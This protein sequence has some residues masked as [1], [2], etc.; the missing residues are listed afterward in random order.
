MP[1]GY[2]LRC[3]APLSS[4]VAGSDREVMLAKNDRE[5]KCGL[6]R[7]LNVAYKLA[8]EFLR[9]LRV[10]PR[11]GCMLQ[12]PLSTDD[13]MNRFPA[14]LSFLSLFV[15]PISGQEPRIAIERFGNSVRL[16]ID[17]AKGHEFMLE[18]ASDL[19]PNAW[20]P[21]VTSKPTEGM[22][23]WSE[24]TSGQHFYRALDLGT[25]SLPDFATNFRLTD[26]FNVSHELDYQRDEDAVV[27]I[28]ADNATLD[29]PAWVESINALPNQFGKVVFWMINASETDTRNSI[30]E[31][32]KSTG[33]RI[34][35]LHDA[36]RLVALDISVST[37]PEVIA[38]DP[39][40]GSIFYRGAITSP[41]GSPFLTQALDQHLGGSPVTTRFVR[42]P[43]VGVEMAMPGTL[44]YTKD[45]APILLK[46]C[47]A[48][49]SLGNIAPFSMDQFETVEQWADQMKQEVLADRMPP[50]HADPN[51]GHFTNDSRIPAED[52]ALLVE[53]VNQGTVRGEGDDPLSNF[54][55]ENPPEQNYPFAWPPA[56]G[57]PDYII[58]IPEQSLRS[59]GEIDYRYITVNAGLPEDV[60]LRAAVVLPS[61][62]AVVH[63][64]LMFDGDEGDFIGGLTGYF[65]WYV[66]GT[67]AVEFPEGTGKFLKK[68]QDMTFQMHYI[69]TGKPEKD[70]TKLGLYV[71][72]KKPERELVTKSAFSVA[73]DIPPGAP[74]HE[75]TA[76]MTIEKDSLLYEM[77]PHMHFRG[78]RF[79]YEANYPD[80]TKEILL[81]V[82]K[83]WFDWQ[84]VYRFKEP[85]LLPR[86]TIVECVGAFDNSSHNHENPNPNQRVRFG[87]QT[88][89][90]MF[91]GYMNIVELP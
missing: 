81:S 45:I 23:E 40:F 75:I 65:S 5:I 24:S 14:I 68:D 12:E 43:G 78:S 38:L 52:A 50:W 9:P 89:D 84:R 58:E 60:W 18:S 19:S 64:V 39:D 67:G 80:G 13:N 32:V 36:R 16:Q 1:N 73:I 20:Q 34:P 90:E 49:H 31:T 74:D 59:T 55:A 30:A 86:G 41:E 48:C 72:D 15:L 35:V 91:I 33:I 46:H 61:N 22:F 3:I 4:I 63:H 54:I 70:T 66:P 85:R 56:L 28:F 57:E 79:R 42:P 2:L 8:V 69:T 47:V 17:G 27:L 10:R 44:T 82:P 77:A 21:L 51:F 83:Y 87:E 11:I 7:S 88:D 71:M 25:F 62:Q 76:S 37:F 26:H 6:S 53:W 29:D